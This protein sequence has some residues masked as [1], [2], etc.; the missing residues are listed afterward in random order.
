MAI[1]SQGSVVTCLRRGG[2]F[3][4]ESVTNL[5]LSLS[6]KNFE[7]QL[8][9]DEVMGKSCEWFHRY[10]VSRNVL[11]FGPPCIMQNIVDEIKSM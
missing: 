5:L 1:F 3:K 10:G 7:N 11:L 2:I 4:H 8:I 6:V 9:F